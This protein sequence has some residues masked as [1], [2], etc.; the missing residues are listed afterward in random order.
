MYGLPAFVQAAKSA[1]IKAILGVELGFVMDINASFLEKNIGNVYLIALNQVGY[2]NLM[3]L[4]SFAMQE[5]VV[6]KPKIDLAR[7]KMR[8]E[9]IVICYGGGE[10]RW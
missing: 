7:L 6:G 4:T 3:K 1:A 10:S 2:S 9:G 5:G 8:S